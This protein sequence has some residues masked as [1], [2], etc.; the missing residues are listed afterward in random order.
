[1]NYIGEENLMGI[2]AVICIVFSLA[3]VVASAFAMEVYII[4]E[5]NKDKTLSA[6]YRKNKAVK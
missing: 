2:E 5:E 1:M 3:G 4:N 6:R